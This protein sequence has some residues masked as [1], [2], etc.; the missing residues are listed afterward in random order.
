MLYYIVNTHYKKFLVAHCNRLFNR[1]I[2]N[3][4][5]YYI[6]ENKHNHST[7]PYELAVL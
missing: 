2:V 3:Y 1:F 5:S 6:C 4:N 7:H